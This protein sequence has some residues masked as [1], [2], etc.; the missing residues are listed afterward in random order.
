MPDAPSPEESAHYI[1]TVLLG[2]RWLG[3]DILAVANFTLPLAKR[4]WKNDDFN[5]GI[6]YAIEKG[7]VEVSTPN[8]IKLTDAG[9]AEASEITAEKTWPKWG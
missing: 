8:S 7:W 1:L 3:R 9:F 5:R 4:G 2:H 6:Q